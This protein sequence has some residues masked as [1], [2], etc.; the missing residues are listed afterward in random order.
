MMTR[1]RAAVVALVA[2]AHAWSARTSFALENERSEPPAHVDSA[3]SHFRHG[4][5][6]YK[7]GDYEGALVEF[8][9]AQELTPNYRVLYDI[10]QSLYQLQRYAGA[11]S[12][13]EDYLAQGGTQL[14]PARRAAVEA[15]LRALRARVGHLE[16]AVNVDGAEIRVDDQVVGTSPLAAPVLV[17]IGHRKITVVKADRVPVE[18][19]VDIAMGDRAK[20]AFDLPAPA[21]ASPAAPVTAKDAPVGSTPHD[22]TGAPSSPLVRRSEAASGASLVWVPWATTGVLAVA[23]GVTGALALTSKASLS[24]DLATFPG[25]PAVINQD[26]SRAKAFSIAS[27]ALLA[28]SAVSLGVALYVTLRSHP[29]RSGEVGGEVRVRLGIDGVAIQGNF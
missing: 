18:K 7:E 20:I 16:I 22:E 24:N 23:T 29:A 1:R 15:D 12:A 6:L 28:A 10:G 11:L 3:A 14:S 2:L 21:A 13:F 9:R 5:A 27:D 17:S 26:R 19:F 4:V 8:R 25:E